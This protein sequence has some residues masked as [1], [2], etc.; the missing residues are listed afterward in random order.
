[1]QSKLNVIHWHLVH[2]QSFRFESNSDLELAS[3]AS[4][5]FDTR[6]QGIAHSQRR[7]VVG[8]AEIW[9]HIGTHLASSTMIIQ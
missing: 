6:A 8:W 3:A 1:M 2:S 4:Y 7:D 5:Y 9:N